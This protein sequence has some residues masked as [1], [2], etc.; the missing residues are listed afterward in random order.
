M[1][2]YSPGAKVA[3]FLAGPVIWA[4]H[5]SAVYA[6][7]APMCV[8]GAGGPYVVLLWSV[9]AAAVAALI[10]L[11]AWPSGREE[12]AVFLDRAASAL[13]FLS[14]CA[15][16]WAALPALLLAPCTGH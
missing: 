11:I 2:A 15:V 14:L 16:V 9:T 13:A 1:S 12:N 7:H 5:F 10:V 8:A 4:A 3:R 6:L